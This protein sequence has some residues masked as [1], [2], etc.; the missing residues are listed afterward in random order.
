VDACGARGDRAEYHVGGRQR[1]IVGVV[2]AD[3][4]EVHADLVG[5]DASF[6]E[7]AD[8]PGVRERASVVVVGDIAEGVQAEDEGEPRDRGQQ[9][10]R[11][12]QGSREDVIGLH[13]AECRAGARRSHPPGDSA[14]R[15]ARRRSATG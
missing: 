7:V 15:W 6:D 5:K 8:R 10:L 2:F 13:R 3:P 9:A 14:G 11:V 4:E 12:G 1:E